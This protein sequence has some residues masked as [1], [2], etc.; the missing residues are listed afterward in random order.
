MISKKMLSP[1][2]I[3]A[4]L[5]AFPAFSASADPQ[6]GAAYPAQVPQDAIDVAHHGDA[7]RSNAANPLGTASKVNPLEPSPG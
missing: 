4:G 2:L 1:L 3:A 7:S 6:A 5:A